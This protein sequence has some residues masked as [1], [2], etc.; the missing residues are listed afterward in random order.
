MTPKLIYAIGDIH[1]QLDQLRVLL[2]EIKRHAGANAYRGIFMG[3]YVDRGARS[4]E[5]VN[6]VRA[7]VTGPGHGFGTWA[8]LRGNHEEMMAEE[9]QKADA[10]DALWRANG[11]RET[12]K[13]YEGH[14]GELARDAA[15]AMTLPTHIE[16]ENHIFVH[17][18]LS[19]RYC[20]AE[21]PDAVKLWIRG[22]E[23]DD[24][25]FGKH[26][27]YG[28]TPRDRPRL[29]RFSTGLDTGACYG[30]PLTCG[31]FEA[32]K[33]AGPVEILEAK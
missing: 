5:V 30:G 17:A 12:L 15:W 25:N 27:V 14:M 10:D 21:Q 1:G 26:V 23:K 2:A 22:W 16:T 24:Y 6:L 19:P 32:D 13:S 7:K 8:A 11:G 28:H 20:L 4:R 18:G 3:D 9:W 29:R 33:C 31:V